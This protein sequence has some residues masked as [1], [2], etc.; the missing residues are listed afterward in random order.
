M[1]RT[2]APY[3]LVGLSYKVSDGQA[4]ACM[5]TRDSPD[6]HRSYIL[7]HMPFEIRF[8]RIDCLPLPESTWAD[9]SIKAGQMG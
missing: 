8:C 6:I 7:G 5:Q 1:A 9:L 3:V 2:S 4:K